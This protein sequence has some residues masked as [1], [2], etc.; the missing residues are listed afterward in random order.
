[1]KDTEKKE[2]STYL[3]QRT[4]VMVREWGDKLVVIYDDHRWLL[5]VLFAL[6]KFMIGK[7]N[8][9]FFDAHEDYGNLTYNYS[10]I[11]EKMGVEK[12]QDVDEKR[13]MSFVEFDADTQDGNWLSIACELDLLGDAAIIGGWENN[14]I[15]ESKLLH[16]SSGGSLHNVVKIP[17]SLLKQAFDDHGVIGNC[18]LAHE[19]KEVWDFFKIKGGQPNIG[20]MSPYILD[21]DLDYFTCKILEDDIQIPWTPNICQQAVCEDW[22]A[23]DF[24]MKLKS[25]AQL[26]TICREPDCCGSIGNS[27]AILNLLDERFFDFS[28]GTNITI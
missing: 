19:N 10:Q 18:S 13:F 8:L 12:W 25:N 9:V 1:M 23:Y 17:G 15:D 16:K 20:L 22:N 28:L 27:N 4:N 3:K 21:F 2:L 24:L 26:I 7:P 11:L 6:Y 5:N 14:T